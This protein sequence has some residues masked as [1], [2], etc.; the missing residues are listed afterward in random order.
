[1]DIPEVA[2]ITDISDYRER[3]LAEEVEIG[4]FAEVATVRN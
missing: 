2:N 1:M 3:K 4:E